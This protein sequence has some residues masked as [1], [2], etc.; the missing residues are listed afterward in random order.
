MD[1]YIYWLGFGILLMLLELL[2]PGGI[3]VF[4]GLAASMVATA[5]YFNWIVEI[6]SAFTLWFILS[7]FFMLFL[8]SF[9]LQFFEGDTKVHNVDEAKDLSG[10]MAV[11]IEEIFPYKEGRVS[12]RDST[13][14]ARS[15]ERLSIGSKVLIVKQA[16]NL[17]IVK[18]I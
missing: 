5:L 8:R 17:L 7:I 18:S 13:W 12:F 4:L 10:S 3:V 15:E 11:V 14:I 9:F 6:K 2:L 1:F 16:G